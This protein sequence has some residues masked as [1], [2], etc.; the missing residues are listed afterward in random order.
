MT[1]LPIT[2]E[3][4][5]SADHSPTKTGDMTIKPS[6]ESHSHASSVTA[7]QDGAYPSAKP[8][9]NSDKVHRRSSMPRY[10]VS[11]PSHH[12][13]IPAPTYPVLSQQSVSLSRSP[14]LTD[15]N[16]GPTISGGLASRRLSI[17]SASEPDEDEDNDD[18]GQIMRAERVE[19][20][21][22][23]L[24]RRDSLP[25]SPVESNMK[26][27]TMR[28]QLERELRDL[29]PNP[30]MWLPSHLATYLAAQLSL[31]P[32]LRQDVTAFVRAS[33]LSGRTF[34]RLRDSDLESLGVNVVWRKALNEAR[35]ILRRESLCGRVMWGF[36]GGTEVGDRPDDDAFGGFIANSRCNSVEKR[37]PHNRRGSMDVEGSDLSDEE[38]KEE[39]KRSWRML[40]GNRRVRGMVGRFEDVVEA[41]REG[42]PNVSP[43]KVQLMTRATMSSVG[44]SRVGRAYPLSPYPPNLIRT[45]EPHSRESSTE[46]QMSAASIDSG[47]AINVVAKFGPSSLSNSHL[48]SSFSSP[49]HADSPPPQYEIDHSSTTSSARSSPTTS[50]SGPS[51]AEMSSHDVSPASVSPTLG[52]KP[53]PHV[54]NYQS[55][56]LSHAKPYGLVRRPSHQRGAAIKDLHINADQGILFDP[57]D[58]Q[59]DVETVKTSSPARA[60]DLN[61]ARTTSVRF[62]NAVGRDGRHSKLGNLFGIDVPSQSSRFN[63]RRRS[64]RSTCKDDDDDQENDDDVATLEL[65]QGGKGSMVLVRRSQLE[66]LTKRMAEVE[67]QVA[68]VQGQMSVAGSDM[69]NSSEIDELDARMAGLETMLAIRPRDGTVSSCGGGS[70]SSVMTTTS[71]SSSMSS[72]AEILSRWFR[73]AFSSFSLHEIATTSHD[74]ARALMDPNGPLMS[75]STLGGYVVAASIGIGIVAGEVVAARVFGYNRRR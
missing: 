7:L 37:P 71:T 33:R 2:T 25:P 62:S 49:S 42:T 61:L 8:G 23:N 9:S 36:E 59:R 55:L 15:T 14:S 28:D 40:Q 75:W 41:S 54:P 18:M 38:G 58:F 50:A 69:G 48:P 21:E 35:A 39:W 32:V 34:L 46:S 67:T 3:R 66:E 17:S 20:V 53:L 27:D 24:T 6:K 12:A 72:H 60:N 26:V 64:H 56:I 4:W 73:N 45:G 30:K 74:S 29:P 57:E 1:S 5:A 51:A 63:N 31:H 52:N 13:P 11:T 16:L 68:F 44:M 65:G 70:V 22:P 47:S 43:V 10:S 19:R